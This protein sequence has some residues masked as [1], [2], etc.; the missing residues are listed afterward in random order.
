MIRRAS[1][2]NTKNPRMLILLCNHYLALS[3]G[4]FLGDGGGALPMPLTD[5]ILVQ[6]IGWI[7]Q[8]LPTL[9]FALPILASSLITGM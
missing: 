7:R 4:P 8:K 9:C 6:G 2:A 5:A 1:G 3:G